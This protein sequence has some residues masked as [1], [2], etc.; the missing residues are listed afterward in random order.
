MAESLEGV[1][2]DGQTVER[3]LEELEHLPEAD[4]I[5]LKLRYFAG[6]STAEVAATL[7]EPAGTTR[8]RLS[9]ATRKLRERV[10]NE[11]DQT[12]SQ[13]SVWRKPANEHE[14]T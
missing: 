9:R 10:T 2:I 3:I 1:V 5:A 12:S 14:P 8:S 13:A 6:M 7:D 11:L 4:Q